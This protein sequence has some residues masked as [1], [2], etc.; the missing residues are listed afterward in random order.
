MDW[1]DLRL[2]PGQCV[3]EALSLINRTG[4]QFALVTDDGDRLVGVITD[5]NIRRSLLVGAVLET[6]VKDVMNTAPQYV[7]SSVS[8]VQALRRME[9]GSLTHLPVLTN[10]K[11]VLHVWS[12][13]SLQNVNPLPYGVVLMAG[14]LGTRLGD[15]TRNCPKPMLRIGGRPIL[16]II[17]EKFVRDGFRN[18]FLSVNY[19]SEVIIDYFGDGSQFGCNIQYLQEKMR[20]GTAGAL[21]LLPPQELPFIVANA[22]ILTH[23]NLRCL[24]HEHIANHAPATMVVRPHTVQVAYGVVE[25]N[26]DRELTG[27]VEKPNFNVHISTGIY[28]ISP[29]SLSLIPQK[30]FFDMPD[31][32][33]TLL[34]KGQKPR[35]MEMTDYWLDIGRV[36]DFEHA[37]KDYLSHQN[38]GSQ[39]YK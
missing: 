16:E 12:A 5:G 1:H 11:K 7:D 24:I 14:G 29:S 9:E 8:A 28:A 17:L 15:L 31:L 23:L 4:E 39:R 13:R 27:I 37:Q 22:D 33:Q 18:F 10:D 20:M 34:K 21:S 25:S 26:Q 3:R 36:P 35:I 32:F 19:L 6:S 38:L 2:Y 30:T